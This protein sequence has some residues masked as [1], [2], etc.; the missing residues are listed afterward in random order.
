MNT[1]ITE[2]VEVS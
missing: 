2:P 1:T